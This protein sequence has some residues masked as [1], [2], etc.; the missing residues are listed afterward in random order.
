MSTSIVALP[1]EVIE[2]IINISDVK[3]V[4]SF[5]LTSRALLPYARTLLLSNIT[6]RL[7]KNGDVSRFFLW[8]QEFPKLRNFVRH[9]SLINLQDAFHQSVKERARL[10]HILKM[11]SKCLKTLAIVHSPPYFGCEWEVVPT[12][13]QNALLGCFA[14]NSL[15]A[16][17]HLDV[18]K[19]VENLSRPSPS[20]PRIALESFRVA[21][22]GYPYDDADHVLS[23]DSLLDLSRLRRLV[24]ETVIPV[25]DSVG[26]WVAHAAPLCSSSLIELYWTVNTEDFLAPAITSAPKLVLKCFDL[27]KSRAPCPSVYSSIFILPWS[28][29][30]DP[31]CLLIAS[32]QGTKRATFDFDPPAF[33][34][35]KWQNNYGFIENAVDK[36]EDLIVNVL[37][38]LGTHDLFLDVRYR[39]PFTNKA[40]NE[41]V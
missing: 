34:M 30:A 16:I 37:R 10:V 27:M 35:N 13:I 38:P 31:L 7:S 6:L 26:N 4:K 36:R 40:L 15:E 21:F 3:E 28:S 19:L 11:L 32:I 14:S 20:I 18:F 1:L 29:D 17:K 33:K 2:S 8:L 12:S 22:W 5:S 25:Y 23:G 39:R 24:V 9:L 41:L